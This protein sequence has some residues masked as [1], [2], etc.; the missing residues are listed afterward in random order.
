MVSDNATNFSA[1]GR[2]LTED[3]REVDA[4]ELARVLR[5]LGVVFRWIHSPPLAPHQGG[6]FERMV[7]LVKSCIRKTESDD[8][9]HTP[10]DGGLLTWFK[11]IEM[12]VN[13][14]PLLPCRTD[15]DSYDVITPMQLLVAGTPAQPGLTQ[16]FAR[17]D[18]LTA[19][20]SVVQWHA[21]EFW[22]RFSTQYI[23]LLQKR[24]RWER[25]HRNFAVDDLVLV[26]DPKL[27]RNRWKK[28][29]I[30]QVTPHFLDGLV[31]RVKVRDWRRREYDR[32]IQYICL[33]EATTLSPVPPSPSSV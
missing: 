27:P 23:P 28:A 2:Q 29:C 19:G 9:Y 1:A 5:T 13:N 22:R 24:S 26:K 25:I 11:E 32:A 21:Q 31:R 17:S 18:A 12:I 6:I 3:L 10:S 16:E 14:R 4:E 8:S 15:P 33:L 20:F 30:I 7:G